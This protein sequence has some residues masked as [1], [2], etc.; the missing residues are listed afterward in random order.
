MAVVAAAALMATWQL[1]RGPDTPTRAA[2]MDVLTAILL[3]LIVGL[4]VKSGRAIYI[5]VSMVYALLAFLGVLSLAR[6][7]D[8]G[9]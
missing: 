6:Y 5:D 1:L 3:P 4:A 9:L 2:S 8:R 7:F